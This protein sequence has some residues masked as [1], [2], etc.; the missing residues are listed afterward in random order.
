VVNVSTDLVNWVTEYVSHPTATGPSEF[1]NTPFMAGPGTQTQILVPVNGR[2]LS[3][4]K[5]V[6][7]EE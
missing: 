1:V 7:V 6:M 5:V 2:V 4:F 3:F